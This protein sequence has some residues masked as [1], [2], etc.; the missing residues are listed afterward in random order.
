[1]V[2]ATVVVETEAVV[3]DLARTVVE[4]GV[5]VAGMVAAMLVVVTRRF[6]RW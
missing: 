1:M 4:V 2:V 3:T 5:T 6:H